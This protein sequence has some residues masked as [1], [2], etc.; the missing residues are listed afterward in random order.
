M[1]CW[2]TWQ[3]DGGLVDFRKFSRL[4]AILSGPAAGIVG[5]AAT[6]YDAEEKIPVIGFDM[7]GTS[8]DISRYDGQLEHTFGSSI[9]GV[10][11]QSPQLEINT[12]AAGGGSVLSW[13]NG[14]FMVGPESASAHPGPA[15]YHK[16]GPI[17]YCHRCKSISWTITARIF[18]SYIWTQR[19]S[20]FRF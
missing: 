2:L 19:R 11:I 6:S 10:T 7:G 4:K 9:A 12:V 16:G 1:T 8:T 17:T 15:C 13:G 5:F 18:S 3:S 20:T 14:L